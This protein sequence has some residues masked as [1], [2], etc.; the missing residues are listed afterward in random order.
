MRN[1][2]FFPASRAYLFKKHNIPL[3][4][5]QWFMYVNNYLN[6]N[7]VPSFEEVFKKYLN[8]MKLCSFKNYTFEDTYKLNQ[9]DIK[10][11]L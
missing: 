3:I 5:N 10:Y 11:G 4:Y 8:L 9:R 6:K 1:D 2:I 7:K